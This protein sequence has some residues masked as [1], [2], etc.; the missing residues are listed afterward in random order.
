VN[1]RRVAIVDGVRTPFAKAH[2]ALEAYSNRELATI[3]VGALADRNG[4]GTGEVDS[5]VLGS[6]YV[7]NDVP[8]LARQTAIALGWGDTDAYS[9]ECACATGARAVVNAAYGILSGEHEVAIGGGAE[10]LSTRPIE[11]S[12]NV[13]RVVTQRRPEDGVEELLS[14][15]LRD[16]IPPPPNVSEPYTGKTLGEHA[17]EMIET[18]HIPRADADAFAVRSHQRA[19]EAHD[20]RRLGGQIVPIDGVERDLLVRPDA[21]VE[22]AA[23]LRPVFRPDGTVT[24]A[25]ASPLTDGAAAVLLLSEDAAAQ[26][27]AQPIAFIRSWAFT[28]QDPSLGVL[29]GPAFSLSLALRR[30]GL[31]LADLDLVDLHEAFAG[32]V[33]ANVRAMASEDWGREHLDREGALGVI[34]PEKLNVNGGSIA[35]GH[36]FGATG[37]RLIIQSSRELVRRGGR[38]AGIAICAGGSRGG[39]LVLEAAV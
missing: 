29:I 10:S 23:A 28:S 32:Q 14:V 19:S 4:L 17:E 38:Y 3:A 37:A 12:P 5:L 24:A 36:P 27:G 11:V 6:V 2:T 34:D 18:W 1:E 39:A 33:L 31:E 30:A 9:A 22:A 8:Y 15:A 7:P 26:R 21:T 16:L 25:N 13:R 35:I 20:E